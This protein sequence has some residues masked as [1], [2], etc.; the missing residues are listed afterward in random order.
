MINYREK[1]FPNKAYHIFN[2]AVGRE[3]LF[4]V[5]HNYYYFLEKY[6]EYISLIAD[7]Y[8]FCLMP[9]HF[10]FLIKL[11]HEKQLYD[12]FNKLQNYSQLFSNQFKN[13]FTAYTGAFNKIFERKGSLFEPRF[14][15]R[16]INDKV[17]FINVFNYI[18]Q[19][20][21]HHRF[22][23]RIEDWKFSS[24]SSFYSDK[25]SELNRK[26]IYKLFENKK[27]FVEIHDYEQA[28]KYGIRMELSY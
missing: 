6:F 14:K 24:Y 18:H 15:R 27:E 20:P 28:E 5:E 13:F 17:D 22:A 26:Q 12:T 19:N 3:N 4:R 16:I 10:H 8:A 23:E 21:I 2:H 11:K 7:T 9:N 1:L 25:K